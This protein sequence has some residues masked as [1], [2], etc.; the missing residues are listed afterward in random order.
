VYFAV[1]TTKLFFN[2]D[3][4]GTDQQTSTLYNRSG[5]VLSTPAAL[6]LTRTQSKRF[7]ARFVCACWHHLKS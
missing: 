5:G 6:F 4:C 7:P 2:F 1:N 3:A